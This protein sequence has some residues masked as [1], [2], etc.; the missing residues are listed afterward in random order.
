MSTVPSP[1]MSASSSP[2]SI[3][4]NIAF[5]PGH[6]LDSSS[7]YSAF[8]IIGVAEEAIT[9]ADVQKAANFFI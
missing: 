8:P 9:I 6:H 5:S 4:A 2:L 1:F 3:W 7:L